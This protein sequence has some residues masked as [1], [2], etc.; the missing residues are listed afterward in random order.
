MTIHQALIQSLGEMN[1]LLIPPRDHRRIVALFSKSYVDDPDPGIHSSASWALRQWGLTLPD[2]PSGEPILTEIQKVRVDSLVAK[3]AD[4]RQQIATCEQDLPARQT[5]WERRQR[6]QST[7]WPASLS[8]GL[9]VHYPLDES[10]GTKIP[11]AVEDRSHGV[12]AG[13][14]HPEWVPGVIGRAV[15]LDGKGGHFS[16]SDTFH[17]ERTDSFSYGCWL[18]AE[19]KGQRGTLFGKFNNAEAR[20]FA[21]GIQFDT[22]D[23]F[24]EWY[25][26]YPNNW[27]LVGATVAELIGHWH[28]LFITYDGSSTAAGV[29]VYVDGQLAKTK[30]SA[31]RLSESIQ[32]SSPFQIGRRGT[33]VGIHEDFAF[34]GAIDDV[35]VYDRQLT[36][37]EVEQLFESGW[38]MLARVPPEIRTPEQNSL[39][40]R[41]FR[42]TDEK[43]LTL[44]KEFAKAETALRD[45]F[46]QDFRRWYVNGQGQTMIVIPNPSQFG[47]SQITQSFAIA[48]HEVTL[49]EYMRFQQPGNVDPNLD[50]NGNCPVFSRT[51]YEVVAYCNWLSEREG[52]PAD[53]WVY[54]PNDDGK[55]HQ[56]M[57]IREDFQRLDGYR[58][59]TAP[60]WEYAC[61][62]GTNGSYCFGEPVRLMK[63]YGYTFENS[64]GRVNPVESLRPNAFG[65]FDVHGNTAEWLQDPF[66]FPL[67]PPAQ[68]EVGREVRGS[69][70]ITQALNAGSASLFSRFGSR[71]SQASPSVGFRPVRWFRQGDPEAVARWE[72]QLASIK[73]LQQNLAC[74][75][76]AR[77]ARQAIEGENLRVV[78]KTGGAWIVQEMQGFRSG[79]WSGNKQLLWL[80]GQRPGDRLELEFSVAKSGIYDLAAVLTKAPDFAI[81]KLSLDGNPLGEPLDLY[82]A[83]EVI[84]TDSLNLGRHELIAGPHRLS[85]EI[86]SANAMADP[87][88]YF[89]VDYLTLDQAEQGHSDSRLKFPRA[90]ASF[91]ASV[92]QL[93]MVNDGIVQFAGQP[94]NHWTADRS[95]NPIDWLQIEFA[96]ETEFSRIELAVYD[97]SPD[98]SS[99]D[100]KGG[101]VRAPQKYAIEYLA[102]EEWKPVVEESRSPEKPTGGHWNEVRFEKVKA[103]KVRIVFTHEGQ[104]RA[105]VTEIA[106]WP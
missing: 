38:R 70:W 92:G 45:T 1:A 96:D 56:G 80:N 68:D 49:S 69:S 5:A 62:A 25:H 27:L 95:P 36:A 101:N 86:V 103:K 48:N 64:S 33:A 72:R 104:Y 17:P 29:K 8:R 11:N 52:I 2:L 89:G 94:H 32:T 57:R 26:D 41:C 44:Q 12:Y 4:I 98:S 83:P 6:Q 90:T 65:L 19:K 21:V 18:L 71:A 40:S 105:G 88:Y 93:L 50:L 77:S 59:P 3:V 81:V 31:D 10:E 85:V 9:I 60:E 51:W 102:G 54:E 75:T 47:D 37:N 61:R 22:N 20:G 42:S 16:C 74:H 46:W 91:A 14:G 67:L 53:Q 76:A 82:H 106:V 39:V 63:R 73:R 79:H 78:E 87:R 24:G 15:R 100:S 7:E 58:L 13:L 99:P 97:E 35:R 30:I 84:T 43:R 66:S 34:H 55:Y 23:V 28:H